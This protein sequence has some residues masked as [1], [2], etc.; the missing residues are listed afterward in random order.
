MRQ[1]G[2]KKGHPW[3]AFSLKTP[4]YQAQDVR[5]CPEFFERPSAAGDL[6]YG[7]GLSVNTQLSVMSAN[8]EGET[9]A[10]SSETHE[11]TQ[12]VE[13]SVENLPE[14]APGF[15]D[16]TDS[17]EGL[18]VNTSAETLSS[19]GVSENPPGFTDTSSGIKGDPGPT[20]DY[21][22]WDEAPWLSLELG[23]RSA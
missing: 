4:I 16:I 5:K 10:V 17:Q 7:H 15:T 6:N 11:T 8:P 18:S 20:Q 23:D 2:G 21:G 14:E 9:E 12:P 13:T 1:A 3:K 19:T 22:D